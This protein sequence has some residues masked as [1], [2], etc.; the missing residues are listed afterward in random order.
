MANGVAEGLAWL[1][2]RSS[3]SSAT[4]PISN[5]FSSLSQP[6]SSSISSSVHQRL[7]GVV[8]G[9]CSEFDRRTAQ[10]FASGD[11]LHDYIPAEAPPRLQGSYV[12][13]S[14]PPKF[15]VADR[16]SLPS[17]RESVLFTDLLPPSERKLYSS[18]EGGLLN[19]IVLEKLPP[20]AFLCEDAEYIKLLHRMDALGMITWIKPGD[21]KSYIGMFSV[22]KSSPEEDRLIGDARRTNALHAAPAKVDLPS[23]EA[24][25]SLQVPKGERVFVAKCDLS[26]FF[27]GLRIPAWLASYFCWPPVTR[28][29]MGLEGDGVIVPSFNRLCMGWSHAPRIAQLCHK[30]VLDH[31]E[32]SSGDELAGNN[33]FLLERGS[34]RWLVY[35]DDCVLVGL[36]RQEVEARLQ[37]LMGL[38]RRFCLRVKVSKVVHAT[39]SPVEVL[40]LEFDGTRLQVGLAPVKLAKLLLYTDHLL[41]NGECTGKQMEQLIGRYVWAAMVRRP[42]LACFQA[43]YRFMRCAGSKVYRLW[44]S[45]RGELRAVIQ[46]AP[47]FLCRL[48]VM[49]FPKVVATDA[50]STGMA[51]VSLDD[52]KMPALNS[53]MARR[54]ATIVSHR[55]RFPISHINVGELTAVNTGV[56]W[57]ISHPTSINSRLL[58]V[59]DSQ[60]VC[61]ILAK[62]RTSSFGLLRPLRLC[63]LGFWLLIFMS[64]CS[65]CQVI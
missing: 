28:A 32:F 22:D 62:G 33:S 45:V 43:V 54:W 58:M 46:L 65:G 52:V 20:C 16:I 21:A 12:G 9:M 41:T 40:G 25:A 63:G 42:L 44:P 53:I 8:W 24:L 60:V 47:M 26:V 35:I 31:G 11:G 3:S 51:V 56:R 23:P 39:C 1:Q 14:S 49:P 18:P 37:H 48:P 13:A 6:T 61:S 4:V 10:L 64:G 29:A 36:S 57:V 27:Y 34:V 50:S 38:Y 5:S 15:V 2:G 7:R 30:F 59:C 19:G 55:W 17:A